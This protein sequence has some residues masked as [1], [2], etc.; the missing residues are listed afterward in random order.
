MK[1]KIQFLVLAIAGLMVAACDSSSSD[2]KLEGVKMQMKAVASSSTI[3]GKISATGLTFTEVRLGVE[4]LEFETDLEDSEEDNSGE[5][6]SEKVEFEGPY[7]VDLI[8]GTSNPSF[9]LTDVAGG[10]Y[11]EIEIDVEPVM[12]DGNSIFIR[13]TYEGKTY[14]FSTTEDLEIEI[15]DLAGYAVDENTL[16]NMLV[17]INL[18]S[19]F[20][21]ID[22]STAVAD[23][24]GVIRINDTS[25]EDIADDILDQFEDSCDAGEDSDDDDDL[26]EDDDSDDDDDDNL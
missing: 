21:G 10:V 25:N 26:D 22:L 4:E 6:D 3:N 8:N 12:E 13:F 14:E 18:D 7:T 15:E 23:E 20:A 5:D 24:D 17:L 9:G 19:L 2:P 16:T 1:A 11:D